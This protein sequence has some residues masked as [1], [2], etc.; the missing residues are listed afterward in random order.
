M[1]DKWTREGALRHLPPPRTAAEERAVAWVQDVFKPLK[2]SCSFAHKLM[3]GHWI[4][5]LSLEN[6]CPA[7]S[8]HKPLATVTLHYYITLHILPR[9]YSAWARLAEVRLCL[10]PSCGSS[11]NLMPG[12]NLQKSCERTPL[13]VAEQHL[14][15]SPQ[16]WAVVSLTT[17]VKSRSCVIDLFLFASQEVQ[18]FSSFCFTFLPVLLF[19]KS[20]HG[21]IMLP[22][23]TA[24]GSS[25]ASCRSSKQGL[26]ACGL[27]RH[28]LCWLAVYTVVILPDIYFL[29][30]HMHIICHIDAPA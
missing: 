28:I 12:S 5:K 30:L 9:E 6:T 27:G 25:S 3:M 13:C 2:L 20:L 10:Q 16:S 4:F 22:V 11:R 1:F 24:L 29:R 23:T 14:W 8:N 7:E 26:V 21:P 18:C 17:R 15:V 19:V